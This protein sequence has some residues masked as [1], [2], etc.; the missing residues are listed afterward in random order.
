[1]F[2]TIS[3]GQ[4]MKKP[5]LSRDLTYHVIDPFAY[6]GQIRCLGNASTIHLPW[7]S[8]PFSSLSAIFVSGHTSDYL[9]FFTCPFE[10]LLYTW[11]WIICCKC[12]YAATWTDKYKDKDRNRSYT[13][14][15][16]LPSSRDFLSDFLVWRPPVGLGKNRVF[17]AALALWLGLVGAALILQRWITISS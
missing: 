6:A 13:V 7:W 9:R 8:P 3:L 1:M 10:I 5:S 16:Q 15:N 4:V 11:S 14:T 17:W 2:G 12:S